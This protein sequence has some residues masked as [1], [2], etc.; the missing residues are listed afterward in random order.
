MLDDGVAK[1][2]FEK[3]R[4]YHNDNSDPKVNRKTSPGRKSPTMPAAIWKPMANGCSATATS[5]RG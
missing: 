5:K 3:K 1:F 2:R 4:G